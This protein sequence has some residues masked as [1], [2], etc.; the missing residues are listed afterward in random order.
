MKRHGRSMRACLSLPAIEDAEPV[1]NRVSR[2]R[3]SNLSSRWLLREFFL[4]LRGAVQPRKIAQ[5][6]FLSSSRC[7]VESTIER[8]CRRLV[9]GS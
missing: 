8:R 1:R 9:R 3:L 2:A 6:L 7:Y 4:S 5:K